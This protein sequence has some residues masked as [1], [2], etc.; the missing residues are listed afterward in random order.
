MKIR[1][2]GNSVRLRLSKTDLLLLEKNEP[3]KDAVNFGPTQLYYS[4]VPSV[5]HKMLWAK[6]ESNNIVI[7]IPMDFSQV[8]NNNDIVSTEF[9]QKLSDGGS[10]SIL[11]EKDFQCL[12]KT[13]EDQS[14]FFLNPNKTC[15]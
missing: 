11:V 4:L 14:D 2:K 8:W 1:M 9:E 15:V 5:A 6:F 10:L 7:F 12:D 13:S 3:V